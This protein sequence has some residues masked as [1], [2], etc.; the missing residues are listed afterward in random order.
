MSTD[1]N[2]IWIDLEMT[3]LNVEK[4]VVL[5]IAS[6]ITDSDLNVIERGPEF[7]IHHPDD[8]LDSMNDEVKKMHTKSSL[9][10]KVKAS[11]TSIVQAEKETL[12]FFKKHCDPDTAL[13]AG[14]SVWQDRN[15]LKRYM[16]SL[17][18]FCYYRI[19]DVTAI[20]EVVLRWYPN[21]PQV[22]F[23]KK[24]THR[25]LDDV[26]ESI[27]ELEHYRKYFFIKG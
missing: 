13:L 24:E 4:D 8:V 26:L 11:T 5:E 22:E 14:N 27:A 16:P 25:A 9:I 17:V 2:L 7:V 18:D 6:V 12:A 10:E 15:F 23:K 21:N 19:L 3:G 20:K 1:K